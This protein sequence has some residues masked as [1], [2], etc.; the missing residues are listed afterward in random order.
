MYEMYPDAWGSDHDARPADAASPPAR[1]RIRREH[2]ILPVVAE[3]ADAGHRQGVD[4][5]R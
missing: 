5:P 4:A 2:R 3:P 1:R